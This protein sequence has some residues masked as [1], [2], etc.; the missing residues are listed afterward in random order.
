MADRIT[1]KCQACGEA[2][3]CNIYCELTID[4][5]IDVDQ[6]DDLVC[7]LIGDAAEWEIANCPKRTKFSNQCNKI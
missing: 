2:E 1:L 3:N 4:N 6:I 5:V 7:P